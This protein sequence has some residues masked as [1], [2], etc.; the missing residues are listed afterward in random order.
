LTPHFEAENPFAGRQT[1]DGELIVK[2]KS[3]W[4]SALVLLLMLA[5]IAASNAAAKPKT[6]P[7]AAKAVPAGFVSATARVNGTVIHYVAGGQGPAV[8]L[9]HGFPENWSACAKIMPPLASRFRVIAVDLR[10]VGGSARSAQGH[11]SATMAEDVHQ[12]ASTLG[13]DR[14]YV[15]GH[16]FGGWVAYAL[17]RLYPDALRGAMILDVPI[18]GLEPWDTVKV[19]PKLWSFGFHRVPGLAEKLLAGREAIYFGYY[20]RRS[21]GDP[22]STSDE[23]IKRYARACSEPGEMAAAMGM[24]RAIDEDEKFAK[25]RRGPLN[26]P[27]T[28]VAGGNSFAPLLTAIAKGLEDA[29]AKSVAT[30]TIAGS[31]HYLLDEKPA[32]T[33][34]LI[35]RYAS[36]GP[37]HR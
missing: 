8:I 1:E 12:L 2:L 3:I 21:A 18:P 26:V 33:T 9:I 29:G 7:V 11:D 22:K 31:G 6:A 25:D 19:E 30:E 35:E 14:P 5:P 10:G 17:A 16:D 32:E 24:Y 36:I 37:S 27:L 34:A 23:D 20:I 4:R 15:V 28:F 13:L